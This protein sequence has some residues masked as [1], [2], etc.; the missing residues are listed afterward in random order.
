MNRWISN[1]TDV[2]NNIILNQTAD[3]SLDI[4]GLGAG[5]I[6]VPV[7]GLTANSIVTA[8]I[9]SSTNT[10]SIAK[11]TPGIDKFSITFTADPGASVIISYNAFINA[12]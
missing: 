8:S 9:V 10:V 3:R 2:L 7:L 11:V 6:D 12:Q 4:G 5:P 1:L